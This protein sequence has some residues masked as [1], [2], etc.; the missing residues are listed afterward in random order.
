MRRI[1]VVLLS[2]GLLAGCASSGRSEQVAVLRDNVADLRER[3]NEL[4]EQVAELTAHREVAACRLPNQVDADRL[5]AGFPIS[6]ERIPAS[7]NVNVAVLF[8]DFQEAP[9]RQGGTATDDEQT[10]THGMFVHLVSGAETYLEAMSY[11][12]L[13]FTFRPLYRWLRMPHSLSELY[14]DSDSNLGNAISSFMLID[15]AIDLADPDFDFEGIDS[16]VVIAT[17]RADS[18]QGGAALLSPDWHFYADD[19]TIG[20]ATVLG[21]GPQAGSTIAHELGHNLG[22]P[23][24][25]DT[26]VKLDSE[27]HLSDDNSRFVGVFGLMGGGANEKPTRFEM[28]AW[29][30]WQLG[31]LRDTQVACITTFPTSVQLTPLPT[32]GGIKAVVVPLTETTALVVESRRK[33]GYDSRLSKEGAL[34]YKIDTSVRTGKGPIVVGSVSKPPD[35]SAL[36]GPGEAWNWDGYSV[37]VKE[38]TPEGVLVE[39]TQITVLKQ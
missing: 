24:L 27:G 20:N 9:A 1:C 39:I 3:M 33:L 8:V 6:P 17:P 19:Q 30:R 26:H 23:D 35:D 13:D 32:P 37:T 11:G 36:L 16:V 21:S 4:Q 38:V 2:V 15:D 12:T 10:L 7:G 29:S 5:S 25:Y 22:L 18:I 34:V 31:W 14:A 28:L